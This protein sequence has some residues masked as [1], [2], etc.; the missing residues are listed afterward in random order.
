[1]RVQVLGPVQLSTSEG[2]LVEVP[3]RK[4]RLLL[5]ALVARRGEAVTADTLVDQVWGA[6]LPANPVRVLRAK[7]SQLRAALEQAEQGGRERL[8]HTPGGYLLDVQ[9]VELD[10]ERFRAQVDGAR[11]AG[12]ARERADALDE[13]LSMWRGAAYADVSDEVWLRPAITSLEELRLTAMEERVEALVEDGRPELAVE[14]AGEAADADPLRERLASALMLALYQVGRQ[15]DALGVYESL[16]RRLADELGSYPSPPV[17]ELHG[18]I[19]RQDPALAPRSTTTSRRVAR[20]RTNLPAEVSPLIGRNDETNAIIDLL[21]ASRLVTVTGIGGVGKT[22][23]AV[24][25]ARDRLAGFERGAWFVDLTELSTTPEQRLGSGERVAAL[26]VAA[27]DLTDR[28]RDQGDLAHLCDALGSRSALVVLDNCEHVATEAAAFVAEL[29]RCASGAR[30]LATSREPLGLSDEQRY[31]LRPL[32]TSVDADHGVGPSEAARFFAARARAV[33]PGFVFDEGTIP[34]VNELSRRLDGLPLALELAASRIRGIS[35]GDLLAHLSD[36]LNLL[37]RPGRGAPRRQQ[38]LRGMIDWSWSLLDAAER[39]VLRRLAVHPGTLSLDAVQAVCADEPDTAEGDGLD[40]TQVIDALIALVDRSM[41]TTSSTPT[42]VRY[43]LLESIATYAAERLA[44]A[45]ERDAVARR[46]LEH[47]LAFARHADARLRGPGQ[48]Q[49]LARMEAER[50]QLRNAFDEAVGADD[51]QRAVGLAVAT[52]WY[53]WIAGRHGHLG[54]DLDAASSLPGPR[55]DDYATAV[56]L[57]VSMSIDTEPGREARRVDDVVALFDDSLARARAQWFA[58]TSMLAVGVREPGE[59]HVD[60]AITVL[61]ANGE[62]WDAAV[63][64]SQRDWFVLS[65]WGDPPRGLP[66]GRDPE[67]LLRKVGDGYGLSQV[68]AVKHRAAEVGGDHAQAADVAERAL[69]VCVDLELW[70]EASWW[71]TVTAV[72]ALRSGDVARAAAHVDEARSLASDVA[73]EHGLDFAHFAESMIA[74]YHDD[75]PRA[76]ELLDGWLA[77]GEVSPTSEPIAWFEDGFLAVQ[78][79]R[80][81][82]AEEA[83]RSL[84]APVVR[85]AQPPTTARLVELA[86]AIR[87]LRSA[88]EEAAELLGTADAIRVH[89]EIGPSAVE[90]ADI[91][92]VRERVIEQLGA[93]QTAE[94][95]ARGRAVDPDEQLASVAAAS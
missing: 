85:V 76:R 22:R 77:R 50:A 37:R 58:G 46:H 35:V 91:Q 93:E 9:A 55:D 73:Y 65:N 69:A 90:R 43:G 72:S 26:V 47:Y 82:H 20:A 92:R 2:A 49:W 68:L 6:E 19:L 21:G 62:D 36:R 16:S 32:R 11:A 95:F 60:E 78:E 83:F 8:R 12:T 45:G 38:T 25:I 89:A 10:A 79:G 7:L 4:V 59:R 57:A 14:Q 29:L 18:R 67:T 88:P 42:G 48:R 17:R 39:V 31:D 84:H 15:H 5:A 54:E 75:V 1:M 3:E 86:A 40:A 71:Y 64:A 41:V 34:V 70:A 80:P 94:A 81:D 52:F 23:L 44:E 51:G 74:R 87:A 53:Q 56:T 66:D 33:D 27:L 63:A 28:S 30:V 13:A 24:D 61:C